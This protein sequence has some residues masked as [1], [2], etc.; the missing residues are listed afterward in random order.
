MRSKEA[1]RRSGSMQVL[2]SHCMGSFSA[3]ARIE[4][5]APASKYNQPCRLAVV[6]SLPVAA[7]LLYEE[8][9]RIQEGVWR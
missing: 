6:S 3:H 2:D 8:A 9:V 1:D 5:N 7:L 4:K